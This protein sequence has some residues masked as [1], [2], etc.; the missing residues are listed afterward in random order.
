MELVL[1]ICDYTN[2]SRWRWL[3]TD[4][5]TGQPLADYHV[6][7]NP[8]ADDYAAFTCLYRYLRWN[9]VPDRKTVS[10]AEIVARVG[11][12]AGSQILGEHIGQAIIDASPAT[13]RVEVPTPTR[14]GRQP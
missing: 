12:W 1:R 3:L 5:A 7:L 9:A 11:A 13:V 14:T 2:P 8:Q 4:G 6:A 10:E